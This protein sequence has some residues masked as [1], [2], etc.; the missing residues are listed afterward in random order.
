MNA[1]PIAPALGTATIAELRDA[2]RGEVITSGDEGYEDARRVWNGAIDRRPAL[3]VRCT[4]TADIIEA[5][6][7]ARSEDLVIAVRGGGHNVAG[8]GTCDGGL[9]I[10]LSLMKGIRVDPAARTVR[11]QGGV[12]WGELDRETQAFGLATTGGLITTTGIAGFTLG[13]GIG[14]LMRRHGLAVDNLLSADLVTAD[15]AVV[16]ASADTEADLLFGLRGGGGNFG[17]VTSFEFRLHPVGPAVYGGAIFHPA[18]RAGVLLRF[19][20][21]WTRTL[22]DELTTMVAFLTAPPAPFIPAELQGTPMVAVACCYSGEHDNAVE[23]V[24]P[25][26]DFGPP[27]A[28]VIGPI[29]YVALQSM[30]D[31]SAP[32]GLHSYWMTAYLDD[33]SETGIDELVSRAAELNGL[34]PLSAVHLHHLEGAVTDQPLGGSA[35][36]HRDHRF[37]LNLIGTWA[38]VDQT[39]VHTGWVRESWEAM[40]PHTTGDPYLNFLADEGSDRVRAAYGPEAFD[41][42]VELKTRYDRGNVFSLNQNISP[43]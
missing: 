42:L 43:R 15:G 31:A 36:A 8:F 2:V 9:V 34:F 41:R 7:F 25:L 32:R 14:W 23:A 21:E 18:E 16:T 5:L 26:R 27:A 39:D 37:V 29:P 4:G 40:R 28:D 33:L 35:F 24:K 22:P 17:V 6:R 1:Q 20:S 13:G 12:L 11:A 10:D 19:Y 30:F 3:I 38:D